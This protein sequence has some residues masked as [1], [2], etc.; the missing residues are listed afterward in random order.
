MQYKFIIQW[1]KT[2]AI[3][4]SPFG[5]SLCFARLF[6]SF[7][8]LSIPQITCHQ[9]KS[10]LTSR[11]FFVVGCAPRLRTFT[12]LRSSGLLQQKRPQNSDKLRFA[13]FLAVAPCVLGGCSL[14]QPSTRQGVAEPLVWLLFSSCPLHAHSPSQ[15]YTPLRFVPSL[16]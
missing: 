13:V 9:Q 7:V 16:W 14:L 5:R 3:K 2:L 15:N 12:T 4:R 10:I 8:P 1:N 11:S 6:Q